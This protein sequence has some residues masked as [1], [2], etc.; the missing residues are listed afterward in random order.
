MCDYLNGLNIKCFTIPYIEKEND[1][2][3][4][5]IKDGNDRYFVNGNTLPL[6]MPYY[7]YDR[8]IGIYDFINTNVIHIIKNGILKNSIK[9]EEISKEDIPMIIL[10]ETGRK[11]IIND[12]YDIFKIK[13]EALEAKNKKYIITK[14]IEDNN[15]PY[16]DRQPYYSDMQIINRVFMNKWYADDDFNDIKRI[17][18]LIYCSLEALNNKDTE[19]LEACREMVDEFRERDISILEKYK[20]WQNLDDEEI[21]T[22]GNI[23]NF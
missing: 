21:D 20:L 8:N 2:Y 11:I 6:D 10:D 1:K 16:E 7:K 18:A 12:I 13:E 23:L 19:V 4:I 3:F 5:K 22:I 14:W 9:I 17:G 15:I